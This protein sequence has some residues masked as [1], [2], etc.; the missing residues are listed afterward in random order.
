MTIFRALVFEMYSEFSY[1]VVAIM[2]PLFRYIQ[3]T[4]DGFM[5]KDKRSE[6]VFGNLKGQ[7]IQIDFHVEF[8]RWLFKIFCSNLHC[9]VLSRFRVVHPRLKTCINTMVKNNV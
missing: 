8:S 4:K 9:C 2:I 6:G 5:P 7:R 3:G 1:L